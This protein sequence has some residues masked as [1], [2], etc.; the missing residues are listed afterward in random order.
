MYNS[1]FQAAPLPLTPHSRLLRPH[2]LSRLTGWLALALSLTSIAPLFLAALALLVLLWALVRPA[3]IVPALWRGRWLFISIVGI[4]TFTQ[5]AAASGEPYLFAAS[6]AGLLNGLEQAA[7]LAVLIAALV[8]LFPSSAR[9][10][11]LYAIYLALQPLRFV[12]VDAERVAI[13]LGLT[14]HLALASKRASL[15]ELLVPDMSQ[16]VPAV[17][18]LPRPAFRGIDYILVAGA[19]AV[20]IYAVW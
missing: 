15:A 5:P 14:M 19:I 13:R 4:Y 1:L 6:L 18:S 7:R 10:E 3:E 16:T 2:P 11:L 8:G 12:R 17:I 20:T 9:A